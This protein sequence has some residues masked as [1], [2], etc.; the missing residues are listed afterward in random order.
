MSPYNQ[1]NIKYFYNVFLDI[2]MFKYWTDDRCT[3]CKIATIKT[4]LDVCN[5]LLLQK[6]ELVGVER[7]IQ[8]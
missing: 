1:T 2:K 5:L 6:V 7:N 4:T 8:K 3:H